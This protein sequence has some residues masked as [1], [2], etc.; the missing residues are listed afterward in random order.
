MV[1]WD[2]LLSGCRVISSTEGSNPS[3]PAEFKKPA[4]SNAG[5]FY[6]RAALQ[7]TWHEFYVVANEATRYPKRSG[8]VS[9][10]RIPSLLTSITPAY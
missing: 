1:E 2:R 10:L 9:N 7:V 6:Y 5:F 4:S 8:V 3:L